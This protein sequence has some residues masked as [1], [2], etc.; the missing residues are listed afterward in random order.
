MLTPSALSIKVHLV[1]YVR[2]SKPTFKKV[3]WLSLPWHP[4]V[5]QAVAETKCG[6]A[7]KL[8]QMVD[9]NQVKIQRD[10]HLILY[11]FPTSTAN[12]EKTFSNKHQLKDS[13]KVDDATAADFHDVVQGMNWGFKAEDPTSYASSG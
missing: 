8:K 6:G 10:G 13:K 3:C 1:C 7:D 12:T 5:I 11:H 2:A 4:G 9:T